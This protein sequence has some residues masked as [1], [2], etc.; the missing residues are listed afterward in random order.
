MNLI[1][2]LILLVCFT[3]VWVPVLIAFVGRRQPVAVR[4]A[5]GSAGV[6]AGVYAAIA[7]IRF[8]R[9]SGGGGSFSGFELLFIAFRSAILSFYLAF[10]G[11]CLATAIHY[12]T[13]GRLA[14]APGVAAGLLFAACLVAGALF[15]SWFFTW[16]HY[17]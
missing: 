17:D 1:G 10:T 2:F 7:L 4:I 3:P 6:L 8:E 16:P 13:I 12:A 15:A 11:V 9:S 14:S 5:L